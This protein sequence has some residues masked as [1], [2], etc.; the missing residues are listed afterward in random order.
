M[1]SGLGVC[2]AQTVARFEDACKHRS[3]FGC[4]GSPTP[5][6]WQAASPV[7][8]GWGWLTR[9]GVFALAE[10][11]L[12]IGVVKASGGVCARLLRAC[13]G[14]AAAQGWS[15]SFLICTPSTSTDRAGGLQGHSHS[16]SVSTE[17][18][19]PASPKTHLMFICW[20]SNFTEEKGLNVPS[21]VRSGLALPGDHW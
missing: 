3:F 1:V 6:P 12:W 4:A 9:E 20:Q 15:L 8:A 21:A 7:I 17:M 10:R 18:Q 16:L 13:P 2:S 11:R 19:C 14:S 5:G